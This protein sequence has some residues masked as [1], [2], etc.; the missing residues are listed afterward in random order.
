MGLLTSLLT[1]PVA[2]PIKGA[3]WVMGQVHEAA[4]AEFYDPGAIKRALVTLE[5]Q[6]DAGEIDEETFEEAEALLLDR[7][8][9]AV[10]RR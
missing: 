1:L 6:L 2:G 5:R 8:D 10:Q 9:A 7:L 4:E 3:L